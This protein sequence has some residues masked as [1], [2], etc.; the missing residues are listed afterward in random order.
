VYVQVPALSGTRCTGTGGERESAAIGGITVEALREAFPR[1][2][3]FWQAGLCWGVRG[4]PVQVHGPQSVPLRA[5]TAPDLSGLAERLCL[6]ERLDQM[7]QEE[8]AAVHRDMTLPS[9]DNCLPPAA[10]TA[11]GTGTLAVERD[12]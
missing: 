7:G 8:P 1:W 10:R 4:G 3:I 12:R 9:P 6:Q 2:R 5:I 11:Q